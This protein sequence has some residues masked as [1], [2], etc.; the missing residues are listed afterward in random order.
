[1]FRLHDDSDA[2][3]GSDLEPDGDQGESADCL[4]GH[5]TA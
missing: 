1:M 2:D 5:P 3:E 4:I